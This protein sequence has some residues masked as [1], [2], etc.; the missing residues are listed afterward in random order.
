[1]H[2]E[3]TRQLGRPDGR[4]TECSSVEPFRIYLA[5]ARGPRIRTGHPVAA[6]TPHEEPHDDARTTTTRTSARSR[7]QHNRSRRRASTEQIC[8]AQRSC[9]SG[10]RGH[11]SRRRSA[12]DDSPVPSSTT[13]T[14][15]VRMARVP[16][17]EL[18]E[19]TQLSE[20]TIILSGTSSRWLPVTSR[21]AA[22]CIGD[23]WRVR[24]SLRGRRRRH[25]RSSPSGDRR[26]S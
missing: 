21:R 15:C 12:I 13:S 3:I 4:R 19:P 25:P 22:R 23:T 14:R 1:M 2:P 24:R 5:G 16:L 7:S 8:V 11:G 26:R 18:G 6:W 9:A 17:G 20:H 10:S